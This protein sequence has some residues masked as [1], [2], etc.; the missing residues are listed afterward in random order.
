MSVE[1]VKIGGKWY[2]TN[3]DAVQEVTDEW[4]KI[5]YPSL[6]RADSIH[7][8]VT[9]VETKIKSKHITSGVGKRLLA[10]LKEVLK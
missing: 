10:K 6:V 7:Q 9:Y 2:L 3:K 4:V 1:V 5:H 8:I